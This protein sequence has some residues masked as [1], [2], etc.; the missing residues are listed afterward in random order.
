MAGTDYK[1][2]HCGLSF[3]LQYH[4]VHFI[5]GRGLTVYSTFSTTDRL[6]GAAY[7]AVIGCR[8]LS[9][10]L[11]QPCNFTSS[12][13]PFFLQSLLVWTAQYLP[14]D[15][16]GGGL[17]RTGVRQKAESKTAMDWEMSSSFLQESRN[18]SNVTTPSLF[19]SIFWKKNAI[20]WISVLWWLSFMPTNK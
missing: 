12:S 9:N 14:H 18:S 7:F 16:D 20:I 2:H 1:F 5:H 8:P 19:R 15:H 10:A 6:N 11:S 4:Q 13:F 3:Y 17:P